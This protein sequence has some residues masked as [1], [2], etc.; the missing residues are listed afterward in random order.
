MARGMYVGVDNIARK[1]KQIYIGVNGVARR[2]KKAYIGINGIARLFFGSGELKYVGQVANFSNTKTG[3]NVASAK[4]S[5]FICAGGTDTN[6]NAIPF[7][8]V[9]AFNS[10]FTKTNAD[11][12]QLARYNMGSGS[13]GNYAIFAGGFGNDSYAHVNYVDAYNTSLTHTLPTSTT[14][15]AG[16]MGST[17]LGDYILFTC[18]TRSRGTTLEVSNVDAYNTSL[19]KMQLP[20]AFAVGGHATVT[21]GDKYA[22]VAGG[23]RYTYYNNGVVAY[24]SS[25]TKTE[26]TALHT[27]KCNVVGVSAG[28]YALIAGGVNDDGNYDIVE[29]YNSSLTKGTTTS[30]SAIPGYSLKGTHL[31][32]K[33][34]FFGVKN[35]AFNI[36][37]I[38]DEPLISVRLRKLPDG[39]TKLKGLLD[40]GYYSE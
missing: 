18:G 17:N 12:L 31:D 28:D 2:I 6:G 40:I 14:A 3:P 25:F 26:A 38:Y 1:V 23:I 4:E 8:T 36:V 34:Y 22:I 10:N 39:V 32:G 15:S 20:N 30:L 29:Y 24:N 7:N 16:G 5:Y 35:K 9:E 13:V 27:A 33:A 21:A 37:N 19:I 11:V